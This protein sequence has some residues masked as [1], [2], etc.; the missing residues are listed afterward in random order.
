[1]ILCGKGQNKSE[2]GGGKMV[3][4]A[5]VPAAL[6]IGVLIGLFLAALIEA[7]DEKEGRKK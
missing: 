1:M 4:W 3:H 5:M 2:R 7:G 6:S